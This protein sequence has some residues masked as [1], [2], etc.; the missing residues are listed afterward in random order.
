MQIRHCTTRAPLEEPTVVAGN[1]EAYTGGSTAGL[2]KPRYG[3]PGQRPQ[4][5]LRAV[6]RFGAAVG[7]A[8]WSGPRIRLGT[9]TRV[10]SR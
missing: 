9:M 6:Q 1:S 5:S 10:P 8:G 4:R 3:D 7:P 2:S